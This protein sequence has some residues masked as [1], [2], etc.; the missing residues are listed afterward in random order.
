[1]TISRGTLQ[2]NWASTLDMALPT[3]CCLL[4]LVEHYANGCTNLPD[5]TLKG[6]SQNEH[7][8]LN[9]LR[10]QEWLIINDL[11]QINGLH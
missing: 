11:R 8:L 10:A 1:M 2:G 5:C 7:S 9:F 4:M 3:P 6:V